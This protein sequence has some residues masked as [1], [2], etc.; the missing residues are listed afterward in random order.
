MLDRMPSRTIFRRWLGTLLF[1]LAT[2]SGCGGSDS[3]S[4]STSTELPGARNAAKTVTRGCNAGFVLYETPLPAGV[5]IVIERPPTR[6]LARTGAQ[7]VTYVPEAGF[8]GSDEIVYHLASGSETSRSATLRVQVIPEQNPARSYFVPHRSATLNIQAGTPKPAQHV[9]GDFECDLIVMS[10]IGR[11]I[12]RIDRSGNTVWRY[13]T[14]QSSR[15][16]AVDGD[17][18]VFPDGDRIIWLSLTDGTLVKSVKLGAIVHF[19]SPTPFGYLFSSGTAAKTSVHLWKPELGIAFSTPSVHSYPRWADYDGHSLCV[20]DTFGHSVTV[21][22]GLGPLVLAQ[23][24]AF[25]PNDVRILPDSRLLITEEHGERI[26]IESPLGGPPEL[27]LASPYALDLSAEPMAV[28]RHATTLSIDTGNPLS[29][30]KSSRGY[31]GPQTLYA[32]NGAVG[33]PSGAFLIADTD[34]HRVIQID[35]SGHVVAEMLDFN[36]PNK[37]AAVLP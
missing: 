23:I 17:L 25:Y 28:R 29:P 15:S 37:V 2:L 21:Y 33:L 18:V 31:A 36:S 10:S 34:N 35:A 6:G 5:E 27:V 7:G 11:V 24:P 19:V 32:P 14:D 20:A 16:G 12:E 4:S 8:T 30:S 22:Q 26:W 9:G 1:L 3:S 13:Q